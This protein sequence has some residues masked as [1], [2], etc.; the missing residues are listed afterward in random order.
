MGVVAPF[1]NGKAVSGAVIGITL[2]A[3]VTDVF[4]LRAIAVFMGCSGAAHG[5]T[6]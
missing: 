1:E 5:C 6:Q 2:G 3:W 4:T